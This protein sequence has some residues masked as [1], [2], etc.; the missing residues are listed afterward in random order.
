MIEEIKQNEL[1]SKKHKKICKTLTYIAH[2]LILDSTVTGC[3]SI[4]AF[5][6]L[7]GIIAV[8][9]SSVVGSKISVIIT[10]V[11]NYKSIIKNKK[12]QHCKIV[13]LAKC[14][15]NS[16]DWIKLYWRFKKF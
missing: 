16:V 7:I 8:I 6:S 2:F 13:L 14:K 11:K 15:L 5:A 12:K 10:I 9:T 4:S 3:V 1:I